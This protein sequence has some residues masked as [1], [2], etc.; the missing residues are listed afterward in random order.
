V[1]RLLYLRSACILV[2]LLAGFPCFAVDGPRF[3]TYLSGEYSV[4]AVGVATATVWSPFGSVEEP[5]LR[6]KLGSQ[7][8]FYGDGQASAFSSAF[9]A[10]D[11][12]TLAGLMAG[13]QAHFDQIWVKVYG[14][15]ARQA[16]SRLYWQIGRTVQERGYGAAIAI[17]GFWRGKDG[18]M[19]SGDASWLQFDNTISFYQ[20]AAY[21]V[22]RVD[23]S[24]LA[25]STGLELGAVLQDAN[26]YSAGRRLD[27]EDGFVK[28]GAVLNIRYRSHELTLSGGGGKGS[29]EGSW[30][31]YATLSYGKKF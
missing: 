11:F 14:G 23:D 3:E 5:G 6:L 1:L 22:A 27:G 17:E 20:R 21:E 29:D 30:R 7:A 28:A 19:L 12:K 13:Y 15:A 25:V 26:I 16:Q 9:M 8:N 10:A 24:K 18:L 31:P 4:R 2:A